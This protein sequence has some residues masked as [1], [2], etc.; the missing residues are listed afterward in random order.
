M[1]SIIVCSR[2]SQL[3]Y[4]FLQNIS[5]TIGADYEIVAIDN[6]SKTYSIF[7]AYNEGVRRS[8]GEYLCFVHEDV[9]FCTNEWG[10]I[11]SGKLSDQTIGII[12]VVGSD[13]MPKCP[14][15]WWMT[16]TNG[17]EQKEVIKSSQ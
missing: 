5:E 16:S 15:G 1:L 14:T 3:P 13:Y 12:G 17:Q 9:T 4:Y 8:I 10:K 7:S 11:V 2:S 6:S